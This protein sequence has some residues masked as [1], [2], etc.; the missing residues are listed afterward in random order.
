VI[1]LAACERSE[2]AR[3]AAPTAPP[4]AGAALVEHLP[5]DAE[6]I[7]SLA[8]GELRGSP[9][10]RRAVDVVAQDA[11]EVAATVVSR[12][13]LDPWTVLDGLAV[14]IPAEA[15]AAV[16]AAHTTAPRA[17]LHACLTEVAAEPDAPMVRI[18]DGPLTT[19]QQQDGDEHA[20]WLDPHTF[21]AVPEH[22]D[23]TARLEALRAARRP[24]GA[25]AG[26]ID[27]A[28]HTAP[29]WGAGLIGGDGL[30]TELIAPIPLAHP[31]AGVH[32]AVR[33]DGG[34][35]VCAPRSRWSSPSRAD[36]R[37]PSRSSASCSRIRRPGWRPTATRST[38]PSP[39]TRP[40]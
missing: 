22:M 28:D 5:A 15:G 21:I 6:A 23:D 27:R 26:L 12:C 19:Y 20:L 9:L 17:Q 3:E 39:A 33:L 30:L 36:P 34:A 11:P 14:A 31:V 29:V 37:T 32:G 35:A 1:A 7:A 16:I 24:P 2:P 8:T 40:A 38:S 10:F 18:V 25:L 4:P 13:D